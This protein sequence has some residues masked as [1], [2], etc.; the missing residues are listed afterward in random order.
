VRTFQN[1]VLLT[2]DSFV[3]VGDELKLGETV[4]VIAE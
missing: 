4:L 3:A 1:G 2:A